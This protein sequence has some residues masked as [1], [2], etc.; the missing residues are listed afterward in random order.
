MQEHELIIILEWAEVGDLQQILAGLAEKDMH[1]KEDMLWTWFKQVSCGLHWG[2]GRLHSCQALLCEAAQDWQPACRRFL[3]PASACSSPA[4]CLCPTTVPATPAPWGSRP[5]PACSSSAE[6]S[7]RSTCLPL[8]CRGACTPAV[9]SNG[10]SEE[11]PRCR[12]QA[13]DAV[14]HMHARRMMHRDIKPGNMFVTY[15]GT[16]KVGDLGL[17]RH[18]SSRTMQV[19]PQRQRSVL[20]DGC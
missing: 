18:L 14:A 16:L 9:S 17:S 13:V 5:A 15:N 12:L 2:Q 7:V 10:Q 1:L 3:C 4:C 8:L 20:L 11:G 19:G 6:Q